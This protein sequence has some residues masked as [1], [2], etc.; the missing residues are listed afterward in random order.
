MQ[1]IATNGEIGRC[2]ERPDLGPEHGAV[3]HHNGGAPGG[4]GALMIAAPDGGRT[5]TAGPTAGDA[6]T[7]PAQVFAGALAALI[8]VVFR[9]GRGR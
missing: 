3:V 5:L 9:D 7:D 1:S 2:I 6:A 8:T 4:Y